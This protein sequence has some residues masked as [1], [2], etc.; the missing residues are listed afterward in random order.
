MARQPAGA[1]YSSPAE[2]GAAGRLAWCEGLAAATYIGRYLGHPPLATS[3]L[4]QY[5]GQRV[6]FWYRDTETGLRRELMLSPLE[7]ISLLV[8]HIPPKGMTEM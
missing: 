2:P 5:D 1:P 3:R 8:Q 4:T 7:F 6:H